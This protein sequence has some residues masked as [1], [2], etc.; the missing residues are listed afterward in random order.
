MS[1]D[2][3]DDAFDFEGDWQCVAETDLAILAREVR[4][5]AGKFAQL[6]EI[7]VPKSVLHDHSEVYEKG[8]NGKLVVKARWAEDEGHV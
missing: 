2:D 8:T 5:G 7:W 3:E 4:P 6:K 1:V